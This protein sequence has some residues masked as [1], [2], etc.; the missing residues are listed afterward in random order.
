MRRGSEFLA[1]HC[2]ADSLHVTARPHG[3]HAAAISTG[4]DSRV[5]D[6]CYIGVGLT[7]RLHGLQHTVRR[8]A[9]TRQERR[10]SLGEEEVRLQRHAALL[11][12]ACRALEAE[13]TSMETV[14]SL[15][16]GQTVLAAPTQ[17]RD[18]Q[19]ASQ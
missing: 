12:E 3:S 1:L 19:T 16:S 8:A 6:D 18:F 14:L 9:V 15:R 2:W 5:S 4:Y 11:E 7:S 10:G 17:V 13:N